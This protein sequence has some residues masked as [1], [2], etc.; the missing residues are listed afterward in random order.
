[1]DNRILKQVL[2]VQYH[3]LPSDEPR[4]YPNGGEV[5]FTDGTRLWYAQVTM[6]RIDPHK[7]DGLMVKPSD[8]IPDKAVA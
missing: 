1:M 4:C 3:N 2:F 5:R 7:G 6:E 8:I